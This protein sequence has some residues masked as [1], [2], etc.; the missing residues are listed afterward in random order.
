DAFVELQALE[1][2]A[3]LLAEPVGEEDV[4]A[5]VPVEAVLAEPVRVAAVPLVLLR[6]QRAHPVLRERRR[7]REASGPGAEDDRVIV[8]AT[9]PVGR[10]RPRLVRAS[11]RV[12]QPPRRFARASR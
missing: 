4:A 8:G 2:L 10:H 6:E 3:R 1:D 12:K 5:V 9:C 7:T 11:L